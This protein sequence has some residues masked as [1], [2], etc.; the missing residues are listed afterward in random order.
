M[1]P[2]LSQ[3]GVS[4]WTMS[5]FDLY[6]QNVLISIYFVIKEKREVGISLMTSSALLVGKLNKYIGDSVG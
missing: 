3:C 1:I 5:V 4:N 2:D 6:N